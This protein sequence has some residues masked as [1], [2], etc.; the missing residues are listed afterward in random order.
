MA[1]HIIPTPRTTKS[2]HSKRTNRSTDT[3]THLNAS[4]QKP[5][6]L[7]PAREAELIHEAESLG[8]GTLTFPG[9]LARRVVWS[10]CIQL[11]AE[12]D[13]PSLVK[14][15]FPDDEPP[16]TLDEIRALRDKIELLRLLQSRWLAAYQSQQKATISFNQHAAE[17]VQHKQT[18]LRFFD[19]RFRNNL[20]G[21]KRLSAIREGSGDADLIQDVSDLLLLCVEHKDAIASAPR[22]EAAVAARLHEL[23]PLLARLLADKTLSPETLRARKLRDAA[24][25]LVMNIERR[26][27]TAA[28]Y[29]FAGT[30]TMKDYAV[31]PASTAASAAETDEEEET[32]AAPTPAAP[33]ADAAPTPGA[34]PTANAAP[35]P[36]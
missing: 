18:L 5:Y 1:P 27:R 8:D 22:G 20:E 15:P 4:P 13:A 12:R 3:N 11:A 9:R 33:T 2:S 6:H 23:S 35:P 31:F 14:T 30:D 29:W 17:A 7:T 32:P 16:L 28:E 19:L 24:Y 34:A 21:Q 36:A 26:L 10:S 25:T